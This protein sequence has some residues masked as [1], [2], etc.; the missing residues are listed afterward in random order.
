MLIKYSILL[1]NYPNLLLCAQNLIQITPSPKSLF[2]DYAHEININHNSRRKHATTSRRTKP[3]K[4]SKTRLKNRTSR[5]EPNALRKQPTPHTTKFPK[6]PIQSK[7]HF[8]KKTYHNLKKFFPTD[9]SSIHKTNRIIITPR[10]KNAPSHP[11]RRHHPQ[12]HL[13]KTEQRT[14][15]L[16][17]ERTNLRCLRRRR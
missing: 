5:Q 17:H 16:R 1:P 12:L 6:K 4:F 3:R 11:R 13:P 8:F 15:R 9:S 7:Y 10:L 2:P 14:R